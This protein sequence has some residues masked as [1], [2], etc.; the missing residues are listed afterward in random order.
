M[1]PQP[2]TRLAGILVLALLLSAPPLAVAAPDLD[3]TNDMV[4]V[5]A[6]S[7]RMGCPRGFPNWC[8][9]R[10]TLLHTVYLND[11]LSR[12]LHHRLAGHPTGLPR[13]TGETNIVAACRR[14]TAQ[15]WVALALIGIKPENLMALLPSA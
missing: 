9:P 12:W 10:E 7:F 8:S 15:P 14:L 1:Q 13:L 11:L 3:D 5:P 4:L 2:L 6:G